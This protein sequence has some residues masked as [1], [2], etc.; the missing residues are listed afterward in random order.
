MK[1]ARKAGED[2]DLTKCSSAPL[3]DATRCFVR[4]WLASMTGLQTM[5]KR[6]KYHGFSSSAARA[7][8]CF[9]FCT[10]VAVAM[11]YFSSVLVL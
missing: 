7:L 3:R 6:D 4:V 5:P 1:R 11:F 2:N 10:I 8:Q 9:L